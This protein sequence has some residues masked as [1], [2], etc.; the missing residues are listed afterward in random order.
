[1]ENKSSILKLS[2]ILLA[3]TFI[4]TLILT[5]CNAV[6]KDTISYINE[7]NINAAKLEVL[8]G[9]ETFEEIGGKYP[10]HIMSASFGKKD[11]K[12]VGYAVNAV[13]AGFGG[14]I[15][16]IIGIDESHCVTGVKITSASETPGLGAKASDADF[17]NQ[18]KGLGNGI[19]VIKS[20]VP[21]GNEISAISG[22]TITSKAVT[23]GVNEAL[24]YIE[25]LK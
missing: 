9:A 20:G 23:E 17:T 10:E 13:V 6:T 16:M 18:Y 11:D 12:I 22:A 7:Q 15:E 5:V 8:P 24:G 2:L 3:I 25:T 4:S 19:S 14:N 21:N 1:M